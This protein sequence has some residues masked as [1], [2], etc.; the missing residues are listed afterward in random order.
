MAPFRKVKPLVPLKHKRYPKPMTIAIGMLYDKGVLMCADS[1]VTTGTIGSF[2]SKILGY[3]VDG[4]DVVFALAGN[5]ELAESAW[6]Q[7]RSVVLKHAEKKHTAQQIADSLR[8]VL[9]SEYQ[10]HV[11]DTGWLPHH[12]YNFV[13]AIR[14]AGAKAELYYTYAKSFKKSR[15]G[16][17]CIGAGADM[18]KFLLSWVRHASLSNEKL[19]DVA[20]YVVGTLKRQMPGVIGGNNL[21]M[22]IG[23]DGEILSFTRA[24]LEFIEQY[25]PAYEV[26]SYNLLWKFLDTS[27]DEHKFEEA[28]TAFSRSIRFWR[29]QY[30]Q[31]RESTWS[32]LPDEANQ[33]IT[34]LR[35]TKQ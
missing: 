21:I 16:L 31:K 26:D 17:E 12:E 35:T 13:I 14:T 28:L 19:A 33:A 20:G 5:V 11:V 4:A 29:S 6:Q 9:A 18:A 1:L 34:D 3:R 7:C 23:D 10:Q 2:Q 32:A 22:S 30:R 27:I 24:D 15:E 25:A 8:P